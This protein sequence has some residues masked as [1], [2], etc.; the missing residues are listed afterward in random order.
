MT[1]QL[2]KKTMNHQSQASSIESSFFQTF[3]CKNDT[4]VELKQSEH[5]GKLAQLHE[6]FERGTT[7]N[8]KQEFVD[9]VGFQLG[10][11]SSVHPSLLAHLSKRNRIV[12]S[13][14][15]SDS[16][17]PQENGSRGSQ[18]YKMKLEF[19]LNHG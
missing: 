14:S 7:Q 5:R 10:L 16:T 6:S 9:L 19:I 18:L 17:K 13:A 15:P 8:T 11:K 4:L 1:L 3:V 2:F 12:K